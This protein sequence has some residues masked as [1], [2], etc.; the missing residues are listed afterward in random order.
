MGPMT[1][2]EDL[3]GEVPVYYEIDEDRFYREAQDWRLGL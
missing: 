3:D 2:P 1:K